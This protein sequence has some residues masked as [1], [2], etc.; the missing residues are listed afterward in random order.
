MEEP[1][2]VRRRRFHRTGLLTFVLLATLFFAPL[3]QSRGQDVLG[4]AEELAVRLESS[5]ARP[6]LGGIWRVSILV[7]HPVP[8]EVTVIPPELPPSLT[9]AQSRKE[10]R[11][12]GASAEQGRRWTLA[13]FLFVPQ[14]AGDI[15]LEPFEALV[16]E[17][18]I[19]TP[20][21]RTTVGAAEGRETRRP[22]LAWDTPPR[23]LG[24]GEAAELTL[25]VL[26][27]DPQRPLRRLPL[28]MTAPVEAL[29]EEI[30][31]T[32]DDQAQGLA[33][34]LRLIPLEGSRVSLG[35]FPL[36]FETLTLEAPAISIALAPPPAAPPPPEP[37]VAAEDEPGTTGDGSFDGPPLPTLAFPEVRG[38]PFP[39][40]RSSYRE[41]LGKAR[42]YW[43]QSLY[44]EA[45]GELRRGE[46][47][48]LSGP[49]LAATRRA[50]E[51]LLGLPP[52]EDEKWRPRSCFAALSILSFC[53]LLLIIALPLRAR[54][55][56][57]EKRGVTSLFFH[58]YT[59]VIFAL[60][61]MMGFGIAALALSPGGLE[62]LWGAGGAGER[63]GNAAVALR[64]CVAYR[65]PD[66]RGAISA[67]WPEG[68]PVRVRSA[69]GA[70]AYAESSGGEAGW[71]N[72]D[73][74][75][76]Y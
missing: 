10:T 35:P 44:A 43:G 67:R 71:V 60:V 53:L 6:V 17:E 52:T 27:G 11:F 74:I 12:I 1:G 19:L 54:R 21:A 42:D 29:L 76:F 37:A 59:I 26:D 64:S 50:A 46:R 73:A 48:L 7:D 22:R 70:W 2:M 56:D 24:I 58:G 69:S 9:F 45:L 41:T 30:P 66:P 38:E 65:V 15:V 51:Q 28:S 14:S 31:L 8:E 63:P 57:S 61:G 55:G 34:R 33:L 39:L 40:S 47:D 5:P 16:G 68:Q 62:G 4:G 25:R 72:R 32:G 20:Q 13:E 23:V 18:R 36:G 75:V 3:K 49:A